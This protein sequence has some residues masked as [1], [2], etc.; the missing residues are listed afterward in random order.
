MAPAWLLAGHRHARPLTA[1]Q[2]AATEDLDPQ[3]TGL[4]VLC[5]KGCTDVTTLP[6]RRVASRMWWEIEACVVSGCST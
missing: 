1:T 4:V 3:A 2:I 5:D 6:P